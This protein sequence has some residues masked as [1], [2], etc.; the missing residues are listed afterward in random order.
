MELL[1]TVIDEAN[2]KKTF[3]VNSANYVMLS[4][5]LPP[6]SFVPI[7]F[8]TVAKSKDNYFKCIYF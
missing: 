4:F 3:D 5:L 2:Q 1:K 7:L 6:C 8:Q